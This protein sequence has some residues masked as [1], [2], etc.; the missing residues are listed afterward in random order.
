MKVRDLLIVPLFSIFAGQSLC[1]AACLTDLSPYEDDYGWAN[2]PF[3]N[4]CD[5][6]VNVS[7]CVKSYP[8]GADEP[9][10]N[11]YSKVI[12]AR[13][14]SSITDGLWKSYDSY[15]WQEDAIQTCPFE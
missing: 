2:F 5:Y 1:L 8:Q 6:D 7:L 11:L 14:K 10:Y 13:D 9:V 3:R 4:D 15:A 12:P